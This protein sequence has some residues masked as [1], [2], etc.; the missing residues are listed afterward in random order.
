MIFFSICFFDIEIDTVPIGDGN[1]EA[2]NLPVP[3][4]EIDT[5]PIGDGNMFGGNDHLT[6]II[7]ID[8]VPIGDGNPNMAAISP[9]RSLR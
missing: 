5:V 7:E 9:R 4:I 8:T 2:V 6:M 3:L 1:K